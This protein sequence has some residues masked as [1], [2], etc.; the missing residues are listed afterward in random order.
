MNFQKNQVWHQNLKNISFLLLSILICKDLEICAESYQGVRCSG[1]DTE[2]CLGLGFGS[3]S[4]TR[5]VITVTKNVI[6]VT[7]NL[8][9]VT[10]NVISF[11]RNVISVTRNIFWV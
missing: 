1:L 11:I 5:N 4:V 7:K 3:I 2:M 6:S 9:G 10:R 8:T